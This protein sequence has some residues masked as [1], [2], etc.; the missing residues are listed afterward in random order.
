[1][2]RTLVEIVIRMLK[3]VDVAPLKLRGIML[4]T[5]EISAA[6]FMSSFSR[7]MVIKGAVLLGLPHNARSLT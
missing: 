6:D 2:D 7:I 4:P 3:K 1:V 5:L